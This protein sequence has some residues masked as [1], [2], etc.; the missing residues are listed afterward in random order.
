MNHS[1]LNEDILAGD[2][3]QYVNKR[4]SSDN[5]NECVWSQILQAEEHDEDTDVPS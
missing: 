2:R 5:H 1:D 3:L 4:G